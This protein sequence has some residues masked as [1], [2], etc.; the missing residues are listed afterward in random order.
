MNYAAESMALGW[1]NVNVLWRKLMR[2]HLEVRLEIAIYIYRDNV[3][4]LPSKYFSTM[5]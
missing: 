2:T 3:Y 1:V 4:I 5:C